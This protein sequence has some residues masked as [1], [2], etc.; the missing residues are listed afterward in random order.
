[1]TKKE[2][3]MLIDLKKQAASDL[4]Q[5]MQFDMKSINDNQKICDSY[6]WFLLG[7]KYY[8]MV[9]RD[10]SEIDNYKIEMVRRC[11]TMAAIHEDSYRY[12][13]L[14][15]DC[16]FQG[17]FGFEEEQM[18]QGLHYLEIAANT[19]NPEYYTA[20]A[21]RLFYGLGVKKDVDRA[22]TFFQAAA[23]FGDGVG[24]RYVG[25]F[26]D[27]MY[28][29]PDVKTD[30]KKAC[31]YYKKSAEAGDAYGQCL[32]GKELYSGE[33]V[34]QDYNKAFELFT[35]S[36]AQNDP[37]G[38]FMQA[39]CIWFGRGTEEDKSKAFELFKKAADFGSAQGALD[40]GKALYLGEGTEKNLEDAMKYFKKSAD[41]GIEEAQKAFEA[42]KREIGQCQNQ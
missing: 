15:S 2:Q 28:E 19:K 41:K 18:A 36:A 7:R 8:D 30:K 22:F 21:L 10:E 35:K 5:I 11:F 42:C 23:C 24:A 26:Y 33:N 34:P 9:L 14:L 13:K 16:Y 4:E 27:G 32:Y 17:L 12:Q 38:I 20:L 39:Q 37:N 29:L 31:E 3:K 40:A 25:E 1:M 6:A